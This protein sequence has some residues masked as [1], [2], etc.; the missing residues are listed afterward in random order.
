MLPKNGGMSFSQLTEAISW[1]NILPNKCA[2]STCLCS[3]AQDTPTLQPTKGAAV[4]GT[5][6]FVQIWRMLGHPKDEVR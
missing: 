5:T 3:N 6:G 2:I 1:L 4:A